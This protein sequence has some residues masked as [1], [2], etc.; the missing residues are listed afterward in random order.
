MEYLFTERAHLMCPGMC[1][2]IAAAVRAV[3]DEPRF[4]AALETLAAAQPGY[5]GASVRGASLPERAACA[6]GRRILL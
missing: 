4:R 1:F 2:G 5:A 3:F 6:G